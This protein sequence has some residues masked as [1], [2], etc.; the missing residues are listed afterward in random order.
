[1]LTDGLVRWLVAAPGELEDTEG[2]ITASRRIGPLASVQP[3]L[4][5]DRT[6][7]QI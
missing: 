5:Q 7:T 1:M 4:S 3:L 2:T 6:R